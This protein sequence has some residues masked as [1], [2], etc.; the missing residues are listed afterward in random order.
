MSHPINHR[1]GAWSGTA[2]GSCRD[3]MEGWGVGMARTRWWEAERVEQLAFIVHL[4][5]AL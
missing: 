5:Y 2:A 3:T 4:L 1:T